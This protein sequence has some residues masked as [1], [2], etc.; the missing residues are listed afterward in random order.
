MRAQRQLLSEGLRI[1]EAQTDLV[2]NEKTNVPHYPLRFSYKVETKTQL[3]GPNYLVIKIISEVVMC[4]ASCF[5]FTESH[6]QW[7]L[8][9]WV[10]LSS[11]CSFAKLLEVQ[12]KYRIEYWQCYSNLAPPTS[13]PHRAVLSSC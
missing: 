10:L 2:L 12:R 8:S 7:T 11:F 13:I 6:D 3:Y 5:Q 1:T 9:G 4:Q